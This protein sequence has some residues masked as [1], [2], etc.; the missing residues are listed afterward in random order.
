MIDKIHLER[1]KQSGTYQS[2]DLKIN[3]H[4]LTDIRMSLEKMIEIT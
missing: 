3:Q 2:F 4:Y 1:E